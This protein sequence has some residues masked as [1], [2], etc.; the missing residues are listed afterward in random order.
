VKRVEAEGEIQG[1]YLR[2]TAQAEA[3]T[4]RRG[5]VRR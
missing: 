3:D 5:T 4:P 1:I 2:P